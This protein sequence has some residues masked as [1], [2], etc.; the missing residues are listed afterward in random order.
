MKFVPRD[1]SV[2]D[3]K[4]AKITKLLK[5][6]D[7]PIVNLHQ[8]LYFVGL[9]KVV[10]ELKSEYVMVKIGS[11]KYERFADYLKENRQRFLRCLTLLSLKNDLMSVLEIVNQLISSQ[12]LNGM[13]NSYMTNMSFSQY[14]ADMSQNQSQVLAGSPARINSPTSLNGRLSINSSPDRQFKK[15]SSISMMG[16]APPTILPA[17][18]IE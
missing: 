4:I 13:T 14:R 1:D 15:H 16:T 11:Q 2:L 8:N 6:K 10:I 3:K 9:Y 18:T 12:Y 5:M 7:I 17:V